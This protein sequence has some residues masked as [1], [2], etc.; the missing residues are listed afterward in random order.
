[1]FARKDAE[2]FFRPFA[3]MR[4]RLIV[5]S[6]D[7]PIAA[8]TDE[9][10]DAADARRPV[11]ETSANV[12]DGVG[13]RPGGRGPGPARADLRRPALRRRGPGDEPGDL[14]DPEISLP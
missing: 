13:P 10:V 14:A 1:M 8:G 2:G 6:F 7:S 3:E 5:T 4:P 11:A 12:A 9:L